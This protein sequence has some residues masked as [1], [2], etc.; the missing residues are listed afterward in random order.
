VKLSRD[1]LDGTTGIPLL[2]K[3]S[4]RASK[5]LRTMARDNVI[6]VQTSQTLLPVNLRDIEE[7]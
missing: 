2:F 6:R 7:L 3:L 5:G 1:A 4:D